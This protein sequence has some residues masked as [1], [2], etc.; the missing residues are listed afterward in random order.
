[1]PTLSKLCLLAI[2]LILLLLVSVYRGNYDPVNQ[3]YENN[4][5]E[6]S[7]VHG[8]VIGTGLGDDGRQYMVIKA[9]MECE[10][11]C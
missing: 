6:L 7:C 3:K 5:I 11:G 4:K 2:A 8:E 1:M 9:Y 10:N